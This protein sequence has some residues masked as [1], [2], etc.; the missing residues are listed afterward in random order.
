MPRPLRPNLPET[1]HHVMNRAI[2]HG[3]AFRD[4][5]DR[6]EFGQ[7]LADVFERFG[8]VTH[9]YCL[10]TT[11]FHLLLE[12]PNGGLSEAM[13][14]LSSMYTRHVNDRL[15]RD[16]AIFRGRFASRLIEN[17]EYLLMAC[18]YVH[19][20]VLD[21][22]GVTDVTAYRWSSHRTY[23]GLRA[24]PT[25]MRTDEILS[26]WNGSTAAFDEF[27]R[28]D[29]VDGRSEIDPLRL[30]AMAAACAMAIDEQDGAS[31]RLARLLVIGW[32]ANR[33]VD[34]AVVMTAFGM[35]RGAVHSAS[36]RARTRVASTPSLE[37][38]VDRAADLTSAPARSRL[39]SD[40]WRDQ[41][42]ARAA[43]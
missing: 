34:P 31:T 42:A 7:R 27:V 6:V 17:D 37:L 19:R 8:V 26:H 13:Q 33:G 2:D 20:N 4:D 12:C 18:R 11:H 43:S 3:P 35:T 41:R 5:S 1:F 9:A 22:S 36:H 15:G 40:P 30:Q 39:G 25:W 16:G 23:L 14:R 10:M 29:V 21:L 28:Y 24:T 38:V 32:A